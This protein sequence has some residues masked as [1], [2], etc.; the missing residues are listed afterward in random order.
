LLSLAICHKF[1]FYLQP[2]GSI[3]ISK[4]LFQWCLFL[5][6]AWST[7]WRYHRVNKIE[8]KSE[9]VLSKSARKNPTTTATKKKLILEACF[10]N[11]KSS[12]GW[13]VGV[14]STYPGSSWGRR[15]PE[16]SGS[17]RYEWLGRHKF[18][19]WVRTLSKT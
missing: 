16:K 12:N 6:V 10:A 2:K 5:P 1:S 14:G 3:L 9:K 19:L 13:N 8:T 18:L 11:H 17:I 7:E 15:S 4:L